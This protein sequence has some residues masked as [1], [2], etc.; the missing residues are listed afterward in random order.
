[1][2]R[3]GDAT[4]N[5]TISA[6]ANGPNGYLDSKVSTGGYQFSEVLLLY[7]HE[8]DDDLAYFVKVNVTQILSQVESPAAISG[9]KLVWTPGT[10]FVFALET[11]NLLVSSITFDFEIT[12]KNAI[13]M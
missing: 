9:Y 11:T 6:T 4:I 8:G 10:K 7:D 12:V 1:M 13:I 5:G 3:F 2:I